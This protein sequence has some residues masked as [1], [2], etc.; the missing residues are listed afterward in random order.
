MCGASEAFSSLECVLKSVTTQ[1]DRM[2]IAIEG[3]VPL[4]HVFDVPT[5]IAFYR[6]VLGFEVVQTSQPFTDAKDDF[7]WAMLRLNGVELMLNNAYENNVRPSGPDLSRVT[8]HRD[9]T[10]YFG[11]RDVDAAYAYLLA[12]GIDATQ[13]KVAY[14]GMKQMYVN[15]P[16]GYCLCFQWPAE[17][18]EGKPNRPQD[19]L[20]M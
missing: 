3:A 15:D 9:T 12:R 5:S 16:D 13:P 2:A 20:S 10:L 11:C 17:V 19:S 7:G 6:D 1:E 4:F 8:A 14:Y 18:H